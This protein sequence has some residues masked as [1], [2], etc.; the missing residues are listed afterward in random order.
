MVKGLLSAC[1]SYAF[2]TSKLCF[3]LQ[4][5]EKRPHERVKN[6]IPTLFFTLIEVFSTAVFVTEF[7]HFYAIRNALYSLCLLAGT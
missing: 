3:D 2:T 6:V 1:K 5:S 4:K 7:V